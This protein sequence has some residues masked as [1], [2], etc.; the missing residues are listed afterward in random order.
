M[1]L[2]N[3]SVGPGFN[4]RDLNDRGIENLGSTGQWWND[5]VVTT[6]GVD[7]GGSAHP[8]PR[9]VVVDVSSETPRVIRDAGFGNAGGLDR[10]VDPEFLDATRTRIAAWYSPGL[11]GQ[12][13]ECDLESLRCAGS[14]KYNHPSFL[15]H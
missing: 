10:T 7:P 5:L 15:R 6:E 12:Y 4:L 14:A 11:G 1:Q 13:I 2:V 3:G 8:A 9:I